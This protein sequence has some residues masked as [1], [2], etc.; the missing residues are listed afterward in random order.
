MKDFLR[1]DR[2]GSWLCP[3]PRCGR[4][5]YVVWALNVP[6]LRRYDPNDLDEA[7]TRSFDVEC[8]EGHRIASSDRSRD[9]AGS[10]DLPLFIRTGQAER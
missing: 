2:D 3:L 10:F 4:P 6:L 5:L 8:D 9:S 7:I 1:E